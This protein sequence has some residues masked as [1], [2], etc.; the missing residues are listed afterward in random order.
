MADVTGNDILNYT[1]NAGLAVG[2]GQVSAP[3]IFDA[4]PI[5]GALSRLQEHDAQMNVL[6]YQQKVKDNDDLVK[7]LASTNGSVFNMQDPATGKNMSFSPLPQDSDAITNGAHEIRQGIL[8]NPN[9]YSF[10]PAH[11]DRMDKQE[12]LKRQAGIRAVYAAKEKLAAQNLPPD[13]RDKALAHMNQELSVPIT[14]FKQPEPYLP[15]P[16]FDASKIYDKD[17]YETNNHVG[18][19]ENGVGYKEEETRPNLAKLDLRN[20]LVPGSTQAVDAQTILRSYF[21]SPLS[22]D[23]NQIAQQN[24]LIAKA[25]EKLG[26]NQGDEHYIPPIPVDPQT[27][28]IVPGANPKDLFYSIVAPE[29]AIISKKRTASDEIFKQEAEAAKRGETLANIDNTKANTA[30]TLKET[31]FVGKD[32]SGALGD[33][34]VSSIATGVLTHMNNIKQNAEF[35]R[36]SEFGNNPITKGVYADISG[37]AKGQGIDINKYSIA[38]I[39]PNDQTFINL[40]GIQPKD[41]KGTP[42]SGSPIAPSEG[43]YMK[44]DSGNPL[45]DRYL[46]VYQDRKPGEMVDGKQ[47]YK[48][49]TKTKI[50]SPIDAVGGSV[51]SQNGFANMSDKKMSLIGKAQQKIRDVFGGTKNSAGA[52][53]A[54]QRPKNIPASAYRK[55]SKFGTVWVDKAARKIYDQNGNEIHKQ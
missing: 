41:E 22:K 21:N 24:A 32:T 7:T 55:N 48:Y 52:D 19:D 50:F 5:N 4:K 33:D 30:K 44:S 18:K 51:A 2:S 47:T 45:D 23:P 25:N 29:H 12:Q 11:Y 1:G 43:F 46:A 27:G 35:H 8:E 3:T 53:Q 49:V 14:Q 10:D 17:L 39:N 20:T 16:T 28:L 38:K 37:I 34:E 40:S 54:T 26:L 31:E 6:K 15:D 9:G 42:K 36:A 13:E